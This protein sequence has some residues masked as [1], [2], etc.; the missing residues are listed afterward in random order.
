MGFGG[1]AFVL[2]AI[3]AI[4]LGAAGVGVAIVVAAA[5]VMPI[6][7]GLY[8]LQSAKV[9]LRWT[10]V[11][12]WLAGV[13]IWLCYPVLYAGSA[14]MFMF[15]LENPTLST[16]HNVYVAFGH[17]GLAAYQTILWFYAHWGASTQ[18][19]LMML[20]RFAQGNVAM[21]SL[22][23]AGLLALIILDR[24]EMILWGL[25]GVTPTRRLHNSGLIIDERGDL[26]NSRDN[27]ALVVY[28]YALPRPPVAATSP[29][30]SDPD[31]GVH[32]V[33]TP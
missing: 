7:I 32:T 12:G 29:R 23:L 24:I 28:K 26:V 9:H 25:L 15:A 17:T 27:N 16:P 18:P 11:V 21:L 3:F 14:L 1:G 4:V 22:V 31:E 13:V 33:P 10:P 8:V 19:T 5:C 30:P 2:L 6:S 20:E